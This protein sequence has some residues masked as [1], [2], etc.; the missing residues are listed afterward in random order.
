[1]FPTK[2]Y[3]NKTMYSKL[4]YILLNQTALYF[5]RSCKRTAGWS[6][7]MWP[8]LLCSF[9]RVTHHWPSCS[10]IWPPPLILVTR[11]CPLWC[12]VLLVARDPQFDLLHFLSLPLL[13]LTLALAGSLLL[14]HI[15]LI[16]IFDYYSSWPK[17]TK[18][19]EESLSASPCILFLYKSPPSLVRPV[20]C[21]PCSSGAKHISSHQGTPP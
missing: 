10:V 11:M 6:H 20:P 15:S 9:N 3:Q 14:W 16:G 17:W 19:G 5:R 13:G 8:G 1:M 4:N 12:S 21:R 7:R 18:Y 2:P